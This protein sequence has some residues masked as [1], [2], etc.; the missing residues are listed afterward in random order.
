[1]SQPINRYLDAAVLK[2]EMTQA[3]IREAINACIEIK[4]FSV[5]VR[6]CDIPVAQSLCRG[7]E[8]AVCV[9]LGFPHGDQL[10]ASKADEAR[11]YVALGVDEIDMVA[12]Y[13]WAKSGCW[14][15]VRDD[16]AAVSAVTRSAGIPLKVIFETAQL[17]F[18][19][20]KRLVDV[21]VEAGADFVKTS[22]GFNGSGA[23][24]ADVQ[25]MIDTAAGRTKVKASG[26]IRDLQRAQLFVA[27]GVDRLG[28]NWSSCLTI[29]QGTAASGSDEAY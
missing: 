13:G 14:D 26:G 19:E 5:C 20:I 9:V 24:E 2:P 1:M 25:L 16:I 29:C 22:T 6:P 7:T 28:V 3:E 4:V 17:N 12:N 11:Q 21:S 23:D 15:E 18:P 27:M 8:T 10:L